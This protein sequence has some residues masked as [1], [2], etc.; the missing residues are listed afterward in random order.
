MTTVRRLLLRPPPPVIL[1]PRLDAR[2]QRQRAELAKA[3]GS[4]KRWLSRLKRATN[5]V[6]SLHQRINRLESALANPT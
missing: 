1:D 5:T 4:L 3:R 2:Q 6:T